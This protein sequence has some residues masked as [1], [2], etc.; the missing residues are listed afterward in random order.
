MGHYWRREVPEASGSDG[1]IETS[2]RDHWSSS[3]V[4]SWDQE[5]GLVLELSDCTKWKFILCHVEGRGQG[6]DAESL[7]DKLQ[8]RSWE[9]GTGTLTPSIMAAEASLLG[10]S[11]YYQV[12][13]QN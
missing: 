9:S 3:A 5:P 7:K 13:S 4:I 12:D 10:D 8:S 2:S 6:W 1:S 11:R